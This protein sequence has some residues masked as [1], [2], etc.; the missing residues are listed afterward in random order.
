[1]FARTPDTISPQ[2]QD[3]CRQ[4][5]PDGGPVYITITPGTGCEAN[6]CFECV[7]QKVARDGGRVQFGWSIWEW[8]RVY[9]EAEH[10]AVY[11]PPTGP[12]WFDITPAAR[13]EIRRRLF[14]PDDSAV[15]DFENEGV[16]RD[17]KRVALG[18]DPLIQDLFAAATERF[19][20]LN[21][22]PG[23][24]VTTNDVETLRKI[25]T[26]EEKLSRTRNQLAMRYTPQNAPCFC[27]SGQKFK[28]C[29]GQT[30]R[31]RK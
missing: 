26:A 8:P 6:D 11:E 13:P 7:R 1:M 16:R 27:G 4:I 28:R 23:V 10:H 24:N 22:I 15:Y 12:P 29:H 17:N 5:N 31:G 19:E 14:L 25:A 30:R 9:V 21:N 18:D 20:I 3:L 2:V